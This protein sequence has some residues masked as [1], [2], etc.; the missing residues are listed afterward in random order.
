MK[1]F[2]FAWIG[3]FCTLSLMAQVPG[4][5]YIAPMSGSTGTATFNFT[6]GAQTW[7]VPFGVNA[8]N[9]TVYAAQGG[10]ASG[11][12]GGKVTGRVP[13]TYGQ[14][15]TIVVG[16]QPSGNL[17]VYGYAGAGGTNSANSAAFGYGGG[18]M[19]GIFTSSTLSQANALVVAGGGGGTTVSYVGGAA[20][21]PNGSN[22]TQGSY[23]GYSEGGKGASQISGGAAGSGIDPQSVAPLAGSA[24]AGGRGGS[25]ANS[26]WY[27]AGGGGAGYFG[28]GGGAGG[29]SSRGAGG[30][31]SSWVISTGTSVVYTGG[32]KSGNGQVLFSW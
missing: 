29:G 15:L 26:G 2:K 6:G 14:V 31:A 10:G 24:L 32:N 13:V 25:V 1:A 8:I 19:S 20:G 23:S 4:S 18:G 22:G 3:L 28:G 16:G 9:F 17:A 21:A 30:G 11:G 27:A 12:L 7:T 5:P